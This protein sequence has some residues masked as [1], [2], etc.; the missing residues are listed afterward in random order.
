[1]TRCYRSMNTLQPVSLVSV[2]HPIHN[3]EV[4]GWNPSLATMI[5]F[6]K[7]RV[8]YPEI[9]YV[10]PLYNKIVIWQRRYKTDIPSTQNLPSCR[11]V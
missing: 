3:R 10:Y 5:S 6:Y 7:I 4:E 11:L 2:E 9:R 8:G 1:M